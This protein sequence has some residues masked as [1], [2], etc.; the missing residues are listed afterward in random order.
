[1]NTWNLKGCHVEEG[2][3]LVTDAPEVESRA[4]LFFHL[5][6]PSPFIDDSIVWWEFPKRGRIL[7]LSP[8]LG[9]LGEISLGRVPHRQMC[10]RLGW[11]EKAFLTE[12]Y[13]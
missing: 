8:R 11:E 9:R 12:Q 6:I 3:N 4:C 13:V 5:S 7:N 1:M 10:E 2:F